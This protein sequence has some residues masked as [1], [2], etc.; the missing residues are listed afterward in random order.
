MSRVVIN[1][2]RIVLW[3]SLFVVI[4]VAPYKFRRYKMLHS[5]AYEAAI[6][7][8]DNDSGIRQALGDPQRMMLSSTGDF[9]DSLAEIA[10]LVDGRKRSGKV[11][12]Q[13]QRKGENWSVS[14]AKLNFDSDHFLAIR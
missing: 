1:R 13:L 2:R 7:F 5:K 9:S 14:H 4:I 8:V 10:I 3:I 6:Y 12:L 11:F